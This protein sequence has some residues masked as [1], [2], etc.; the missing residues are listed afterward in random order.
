MGNRILLSSTMQNRNIETSKDKN[1]KLSHH[2]IKEYMIEKSSENKRV[3][4]AA[5]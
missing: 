1:T 4:E 2:E 3:L 5:F